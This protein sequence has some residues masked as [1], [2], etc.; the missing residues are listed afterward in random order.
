MESTR[1]LNGKNRPKRFEIMSSV[2]SAQVLSIDTPAAF[3]AALT[4]CVELLRG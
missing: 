1:R 3:K 4:Q 2:M